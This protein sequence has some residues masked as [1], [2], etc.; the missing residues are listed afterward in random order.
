GSE[1][2]R[3][4][5]VERPRLLHHKVGHMVAVERLAA[6]VRLRLVVVTTQESLDL[7]ADRCLDR[8][9]VCPVDLE[10]GADALDEVAGYRGDLRIRIPVLTRAS[11]R[12]IERCLFNTQSERLVAAASF[13]HPLR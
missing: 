10:V 1:Y 4:Q 9:A 12:V 6:A 8:L 11:N 13:A 7:D 5:P 2:L 3:P